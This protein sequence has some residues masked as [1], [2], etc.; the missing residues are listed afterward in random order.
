MNDITT[1]TIIAQSTPIGAGAIAVIRLSGPQAITLSDSFIKL[2]NQTALTLQASHTIHYG[3]VYDNDNLVDQVMV[4]VMR[5]PRT[6]TGENV[7]EI[8]C[9]NNQ[10]LIEKIISIALKHGAILAQKGEFTQRAF[11]HNK[12]DLIQA[13]AINDLIHAQTEAAVKKS[14]AQ[15]EGSFSHQMQ[16][17]EQEL[18]RALA[19]CEASFDFLDEN[20]GFASQIKAHL[21]TQQQLIAHLQKTFDQQH[22]I[23]QGIRIALVGSVNAGKS[24]L[25]NKLIGHNRAIVSSQAGTTR[26]TIEA[27]LTRNG[28]FWTLIDTAGLRSTHDIIETQGIER[29]YQEAEKADIVIVVYDLSRIITPEE[30]EVY[31]KLIEKYAS[32]IIIVGNKADLSHQ[33]TVP[34]Q[35]LIV[36]TQDGTGLNS[37]ESAIQTKVHNLLETSNAPFL[38]N[39][40]HYHI[41]TTLS[42]AIENIINMLNKEHV[43]YELVSY[44]LREA[45]E[46]I[47][48]LTGKSISE[49]GMDLVFKEFC[50]GK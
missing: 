13:E 7:V 39:K 14:L 8:S 26:D 29:S 24:S 28:V 34:V 38:V 44:H 17:L 42:Q 18:V 20:A 30:Q 25:F 4:A 6:F 41:L 31:E 3:K 16:M 46:H 23:K 15:L 5:A 45:L 50:V 35:A 48:Q 36:S 37:L 40:R 1:S 47:S 2:A 49:A 43:E 33:L 11:L 10:F 12:I 19:W 32:K 22:H 9:H 21:Q 27:Q